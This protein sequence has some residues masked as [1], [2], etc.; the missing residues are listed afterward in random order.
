VNVHRYNIVDIDDFSTSGFSVAQKS[1]K[2][3]E[4]GGSHKFKDIIG[5]YFQIVATA[6]VQILH[7]QLQVISN[8]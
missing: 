8:R 2:L 5:R 6:A 7:D 4:T 1:L 3:E